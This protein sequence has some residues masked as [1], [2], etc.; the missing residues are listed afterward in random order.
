VN[1]LKILWGLYNNEVSG[2]DGVDLA[3]VGKPRQNFITFIFNQN[4]S[5]IITISITKIYFI[6]ATSNCCV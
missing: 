5:Y 3:I 4:V 2:V 1:S 6:N